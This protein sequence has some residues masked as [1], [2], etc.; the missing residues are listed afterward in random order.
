L[1]SGTF[2]NYNGFDTGT[3]KFITKSI[4]PG[5]DVIAGSLAFGTLDATVFGLM[6]VSSTIAEGAFQNCTSLTCNSLTIPAS[7]LTI[8]YS[9]FE[10][11]TGLGGELTF[12]IRL[13]TINTN[14]FNNCS[15]FFSIVGNFQGNP[16][17]EN[18][19]FYG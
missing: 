16:T 19:A 11:C 14:A 1:P 7:V 9:A 10:N 5:R 2:G 13:T 12:G 6:N 18:K 8:E 15:N 3:T 4:A 17:V